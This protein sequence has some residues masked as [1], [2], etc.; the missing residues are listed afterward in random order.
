M[1]KVIHKI[2][3]TEKGEYILRQFEGVITTEDIM[4]SFVHILN[5]NMISKSCKGILTDLL[6]VQLD[7]NMDTFKN[8]VIYIKSNPRLLAVKI[9]VVVDSSDKIVFPMMASNEP[10]LNVQ[11]FST[12]IAAENWI[13]Q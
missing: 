5:T 12:M 1:G 9:A 10:G 2:I 6:N 3:K 8:L 13:L 11:P 4:D 7:F